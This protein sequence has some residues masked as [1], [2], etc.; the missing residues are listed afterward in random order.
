MTYLILLARLPVMVLGAW[1]AGTA[2]LRAVWWVLER[3]Q[4]QTEES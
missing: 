1:L 4:R 2:Y 3:K